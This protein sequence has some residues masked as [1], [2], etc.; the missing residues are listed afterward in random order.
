MQR[1]A[2][3][4]FFALLR[5]AIN[6]TPLC[7]G[8][9]HAIT[10]AL[11][12]ALFQLSKRHDL[13][14]LVGE[15]LD[16]N[17]LL[18]EGTKARERFLQEHYLAVYRHEQLQHEFEQICTAL[19]QAK[20]AFV[21]LKGCVI[22]QY[23]PEPWMRTSCDI[24]ILVHEED[25]E[26]SVRALT[27]SLGYRLSE[28]STAHDVSLFS[29]NGVH[30]ELHYSL[31]EQ[32]RVSAAREILEQVWC[33][34]KENDACQKEAVDEMF[35]FYHIAHMAKHFEIGG[36]GVRPFLDVYLLQKHSQYRTAQCQQLLKD[37]G[38][39]TFATAVEETALVWFGQAEPTALVQEMQSYV[40]YAGMY[41]DTKNRVAV[42]HAQKGGRFQ[43]LRSRIFLPYAQLTLQYPNLEKRKYLLPFYQV[44]R[45]FRLLLGKNA[46][47]VAR[48]LKANV[49]VQSDKKERVAK[50]FKDLDL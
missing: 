22:R 3:E 45:W 46:K 26:L 17:G 13:A 49:T 39:L 4:A 20:I 25:L 36:C 47:N 42:Q 8:L 43:Y 27:D 24:D 21:P 14:H 33:N 23:Y 1:T 10:P 48:Q 38:L 15:A 2:E 29:P 28:Y 16:K 11:L 30:L 9:K 5:F 44:K 40:L 37:G 35:Y 50:L 7:D 31:A 41:A 19:A 34:V 12:P 6:G 18:P 32:G